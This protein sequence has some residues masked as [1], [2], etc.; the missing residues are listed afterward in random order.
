MPSNVATVL[1]VNAVVV[2]NAFL[3]SKLELVSVSVQMLHGGIVIF[4]NSQYF[5]RILFLR[6]WAAL[7]AWILGFCAAVCERED[8]GARLICGG[9]VGP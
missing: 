7:T 5:L 4:G 1:A 8:L 2:A 9:I 6:D 3:G